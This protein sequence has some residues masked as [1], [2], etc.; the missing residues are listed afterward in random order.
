MTFARTSAGYG[1]CRPK[2]V[3]GSFI[4]RDLTTHS[5]DLAIVIAALPPDVR[6][7][8]A[9]PSVAHVPGAAPP[10]GRSPGTRRAKLRWGKAATAHQG[11]KPHTRSQTH[12]F[13]LKGFALTNPRIGCSLTY[14]ISINARPVDS[15]V[16]PGQLAG[17]IIYE[18]LHLLA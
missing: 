14:P 9:L 12:I 1:K 3:R 4:A 8:S 16:M 17:V 6:K 13:N 18:A 7:G 11:A 2:T 15:K 10:F 5:T